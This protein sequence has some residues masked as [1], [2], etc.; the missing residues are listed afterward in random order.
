MS[1]F[2]RRLIIAT[3]AVMAAVLVGGLV[4]LHWLTW[5]KPLTFGVCYAGFMALQRYVD[6]SNEEE[7]N[8]E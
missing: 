8:D 6:K 4:P 3:A 5:C 1:K 2:L 7:D